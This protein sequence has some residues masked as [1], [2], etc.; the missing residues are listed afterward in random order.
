MIN[1]DSKLP[2]TLDDIS[3]D[4]QQTL[5]NRIAT[6]IV[7]RHLTVPAILAL[8]MCKPLN[9]LGSQVLLAF[10]PFVQSIINSIDYQKFSLI[11]EKDANV[12]SL[13][14]LIEDLAKEEKKC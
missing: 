1:R 2:L 10:N 12:E 11:I 9:F 5:L 7:E 14:Q 3:E 4:E 6:G 13:I 8:E